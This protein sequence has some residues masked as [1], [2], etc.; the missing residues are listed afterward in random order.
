MK[1]ILCGGETSFF[2][3]WRGKSYFQCSYCKSIMLH[4]EDYV[5]LE[6]EKERYQ[7]HNNDVNDKRYQNFVSP[8][9]N[10]VLEERSKDDK[11]L[12]FGSGTGPVIT[13]MLR[14]KGYNIKVY[15]PFFANYKKRLEKT[16]DYIV[17]CE[18]MEHFHQPKEEFKKLKGLLKPKGS[19][20][21]MTEIYD[22]AID[23]DSWNYKNDQTHVFFYHKKALEYIKQQYS[24]G[25]MEIIDDMVVYK[26]KQES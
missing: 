16:Y 5:S 14:D 21:L 20:H 22:Q 19:L 2:R 12:D 18:V 8:I 3:Q 10:K 15:D 11:G 9:V 6:E 17:C 4:S 1:C 13:K 26:V 7:E 24:F 23:F 25:S